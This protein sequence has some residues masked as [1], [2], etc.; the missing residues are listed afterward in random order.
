MRTGLNLLR[1]GSSDV[2][3]TESSGIANIWSVGFLATEFCK[4]LIS[5]LISIAEWSE[6]ST[7]FGRLNIEIVG[8]NLLGA[9]VCVCVSMCCVVLCVGR[10]LASGWSPVQGVLPIV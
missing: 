10:T 6:A 4:L 3:H 5:V 7:V 2:S 1:I 9:W 8:L